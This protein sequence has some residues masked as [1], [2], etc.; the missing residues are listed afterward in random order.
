MIAGA[1]H[2]RCEMKPETNKC[3]YG[4]QSAPM[5]CSAVV[6]C[7]NGMRWWCTLVERLTRRRL[8][9]TKPLQPIASSIFYIL[10]GSRPVMLNIALLILADAN[11]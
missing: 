10:R 3:T 4:M 8:A 1:E 5:V 9:A 7:T 11:L 2:Q 6:E